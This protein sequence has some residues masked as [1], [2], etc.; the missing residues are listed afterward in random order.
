[1]TESV[2]NPR[3]D[4]EMAVYRAYIVGQHGL[5]IRAVKMNCVDDDVAIESAKHLVDSHDVELWQRDRP[6]AWFD[7]ASNRIIRK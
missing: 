5:F 6:I 7:V 2:G 3:L 1:V 4:P